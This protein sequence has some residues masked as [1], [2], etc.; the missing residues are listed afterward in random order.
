MTTK[1]K[2]E[3][4]SKATIQTQPQIVY[5]AIQTPDG[6]VIRSITRYDYVTH[7]DAN[8]KTYAVDGG[9]VYLRRSG[10]S[11]YVELSLTVEDPI[12]LIREKFCWGTF[13]KG[14]NQPLKRVL[15]KDLT[16]AHI[17]AII[18][19]QKQLPESL[20]QVFEREL[21]YRSDNGLFIDEDV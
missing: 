16:N 12:E 5:N 4:G 8:G 11:D 9:L 17:L 1:S 6:T 19:T 15:L 3:V 21:K 7:Q 10:D 2:I 13:G 20:I 14:G 18:E